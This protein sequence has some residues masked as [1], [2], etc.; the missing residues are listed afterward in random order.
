[1]AMPMNR[2][3]Y[4]DYRG[5]KLP[6][7]ENGDDTGQLVEYVDGGKSNDD[8]HKGYISWS[9]NEVF[10]NAYRKTSGLTFGLALEALK[11]G[12]KVCRAGWNGKSMWLVLAE[13]TK[14]K[15]VDMTAGTN[16]ERAGISKICIDPH[17]DM[18]T[19]KGT[20]QPGWLASQ[21]DM[22]ADDWM[23]IE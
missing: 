14:G 23:I 6:D 9:P 1:M 15:V 17:I 4:N 5:W 7:D 12:K 2:Q 21:A 22:L 13:G 11:L 8:R 18:Y 3:E 19:A 20:M 10:A 16:Y